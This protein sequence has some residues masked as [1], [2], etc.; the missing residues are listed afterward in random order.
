LEAPAIDYFRAYV[1][2]FDA[3][4]AK[5]VPELISLDNMEKQISAL[6]PTV[7]YAEHITA[8]NDELTQLRQQQ[9]AEFEAYLD[10]ELQV[11]TAGLSK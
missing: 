2:A 7:N 4:Y 9:L 8:V 1:A 10:Q 6:P 11:L 3:I 5:R